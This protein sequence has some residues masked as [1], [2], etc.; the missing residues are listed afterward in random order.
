MTRLIAI[1]GGSGAGKT[2]IADA[3]SRRLGQ[4]ALVIAEDDYYR[5]STHHSRVRRRHANFDAPS[6]KD[7]A[8]LFACLSAAR[9]GKTFE[10]PLY[11]M[12]THTRRADTERIEPRELMIVEGIHVLAFPKLRALFDLT[13]FVEADEV[14]C[15]SAGA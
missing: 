1:T 8:A 4:R 3:L 10:K 7:E 5:C 13:V 6:A 9:A 2:C 15:A 14:A 12:T 11:D